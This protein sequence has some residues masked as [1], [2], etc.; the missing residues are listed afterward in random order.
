MST[1]QTREQWQQL[2]DRLTFNGQ[3]YINGHY[4]NAIEGDLFA[5]ISPING[6]VLTEVASCGPEDANQAVAC[7]RAAFESGVWRHTAPAER[8]QTLIRFAD[9]I[10]ANQDELAL[11]ET[12]D[13]GKPIRDS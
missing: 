8:K 6:Q 1:P 10:L 7:A 5:C 13:M 2:A 4:Q 3:A 11:L 12:L 9:L